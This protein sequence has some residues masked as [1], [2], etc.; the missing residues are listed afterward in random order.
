M[1]K[2]ITISLIS[3]PV[4]DLLAGINEKGLCYLGFTGEESIE[5]QR[6][7]L[8]KKFKTSFIKRKSTLFDTLKLQLD[9]YFEG[10]RRTFDIPLDFIGT[11]FQKNV[12]K[13]LLKIPYGKTNSYQ[14]QAVSVGNQKAVR[15]VANANGA[16]NI[17][18]VI[19]CHRVI[20]KDGSLTGFGGG[21][22]RKKILLDL[23]KK[24]LK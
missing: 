8:G 1:N 19:P 2:P 21:L 5:K 17:V 24:N 22:W 7:T 9:E 14:E 4:G 20:G 3:S 6:E 12:W 18:I 16:N 11:D 10:K 23:E 13:T 15:A